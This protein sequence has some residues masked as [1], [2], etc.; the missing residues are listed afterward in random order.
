[1]KTYQKRK[2]I[3][4]YGFVDL[5]KN[6]LTNI[7]FKSTLTPFMK[8]SVTSLA[9]SASQRIGHNIGERLGDTLIHQRTDDKKLQEVREQTLKDLELIPNNT[10]NNSKN[11]NKI[12]EE[13]KLSDPPLGAL[14]S[15][16]GLKKKKKIKGG[17]IKYLI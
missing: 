1:M 3:K 12:L 14:Y 13:L 15:G 17:A 6:V 7:P 11:K 16:S 2:Y 4:G 8:K 9:N 10:K 5:V